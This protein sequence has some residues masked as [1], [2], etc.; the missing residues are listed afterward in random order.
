MVGI[1]TEERRGNSCTAQDADLDCALLE[2][3]SAVVSGYVGAGL[4]GQRGRGGD[5]DEQKGESQTGG[6]AARAISLSD[7][8][9]API[10]TGGARM[11]KKR[12][13]AAKTAAKSRKASKKT[14]S[15]KMTAKRSAKSSA[16]RSTKRSAK[17][18]TPRRSST[19]AAAAPSRSVPRPAPAAA[20]AQ[21]ASLDTNM[22]QTLP[23]D[24]VQL[25]S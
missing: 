25:P 16:K 2:R 24:D 18:A 22:E 3:H 7:R 15:R 14:A 12:R 8:I 6:S 4:I 9:R 13:K 10:S 1:R 21:P 20:P 17:R 11:A 5:D 19:R 23:L